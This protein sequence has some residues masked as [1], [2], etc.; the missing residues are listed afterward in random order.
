M[1]RCTAGRLPPMTTEVGKHRVGI[2]GLGTVGSRFVEQFG[3]HEQFQ[4]V[5]AWDPDP[6]AC[7][8]HAEA[9][10]I[11]P[12]AATVIDT[13]DVVYVAVPPLFHREYVEACLAAGTAVFC[14]KPLGIDVDESRELV[15]AVEASG[16]PAGVNFVFSGAPS[17]RALESLAAEGELGAPRS[18]ELRL[19]FGE[20]PRAWHAKAQWLKLRDQGGWVREVVSHFLFVAARV[21]GPLRLVSSQ[22]TYP[23]GPEGVAS[24]ADGVARFD[25]GGTPLLMLGTSEGG[26]GDVVDLTIRGRDGAARIW[27][28]W[29]W[30]RS[31]RFSRFFDLVD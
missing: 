10:D 29:R 9:V 28:I 11:A 31:I 13:A 18:A 4:L 20:W 14:E 5:A 7:A 22:L 27:E 19:H 21:L 24:E 16:L 12:D 15:A 26:G 23:D 8:L 1:T 17:A 25:A 6:A 30:P 2:I 3:L